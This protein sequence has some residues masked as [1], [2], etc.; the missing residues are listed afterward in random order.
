MA[1]APTKR[2]HLAKTAAAARTHF[3][4]MGW[5]CR[6]AAP[7]LGVCFQHLNQV[8]T[9]DR[10]SRRLTTAILA[11]PPRNPAKPCSTSPK[12]K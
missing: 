6:T 8:L 12:S 3:Y 1:Y 7:V 11:L 9:G 10:E 2:P 4:A 5:S